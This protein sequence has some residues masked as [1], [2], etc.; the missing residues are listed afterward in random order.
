MSNTEG[1]NGGATFI[2]DSGTGTVPWVNPGNA[3]FS[4]G[5]FSITG[6]LAASATSNLLRATGFGFSIPSTA[7]IVGIQLSVQCMANGSPA[8]IQD[9]GAFV[10]VFGSFTGTDHSA[11]ITWPAYPTEGARVFG[12]A[13]DLWGQTWTP[14]NINDPNF[15]GAIG[16][17][18]AGLSTGLA[19][20]D[21]ISIVVYYT[22]G[23]NQ[24]MPRVMVAR[25][26]QAAYDLTQRP[27]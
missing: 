22:L 13:T 15:G 21:F 8:N 24:D 20:I 1:P 2:N 10:A 11:A 27:D 26:P 9:G 12:G 6:S 17:T 19:Y 25:P 23:A 3:Q 14:A 18:N 7:T 5:V 4:D 16:A